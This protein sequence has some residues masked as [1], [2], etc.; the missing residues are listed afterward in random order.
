MLADLRKCRAARELGVG[1]GVVVFAGG[2]AAGDGAVACV[3]VVVEKN[4]QRVSTGFTIMCRLIGDRERE[5]K[6]EGEGI[7]S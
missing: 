7:G 2:D 5:K 6:G 3:A 1:G 4:K